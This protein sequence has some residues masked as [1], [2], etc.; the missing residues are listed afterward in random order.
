MRP[1]SVLGANQLRLRSGV[2][3][4]AVVRE[5]KSYH[6]VGNDFKLAAGDLLVL[7]GGHKALDDAGRMLSPAGDNHES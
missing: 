7:L 2:S 5:G 4:I 3:V 6:N 1:S